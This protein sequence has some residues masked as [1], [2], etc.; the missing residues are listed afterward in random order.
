MRRVF[1]V[2]V[3]A[4]TAITI[5]ALGAGMQSASAAPATTNWTGLYIGG[6]VG[7][8]WAGD[9]AFTM[10]DPNGAFSFNG[11]PQSLSADSRGIIGGI[12]VGYNWQIMPSWLLGIEGEW[13]FSSL[14]LRAN[15][16]ITAGGVTFPGSN[17]FTQ[18]DPQ[19]IGSIR[20]RLAFTT[21]TWLIYGTGGWAFSH[22]EYKG[23]WTCGPPSCGA[24]FVSIATFSKDVSGWVVG[25][26]TEFR[27]PAS[28]WIFG[29][30]YLYYQLNASADATAALNIGAGGCVAGAPCNPMTFGDFNVHVLRARL[31]FKL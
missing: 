20:G 27:A 14:S 21:P 29:F 8:A 16:P 13:S 7:G 12:H 26:G 22:L 18:I 23:G 6:N 30:E 31:G 1:S 11:F 25:A 28:P 17:A 3:A 10:T 9:S 15:A 4:T 19:S 5:A 2:A 24:Q